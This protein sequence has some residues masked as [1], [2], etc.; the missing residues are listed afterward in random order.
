MFASRFEALIPARTLTAVA[1]CLTLLAVG[2][3]KKP[4]RAAPPV[5][6]PSIEAEPRPAP[7][8]QSAPNE[9]P[10]PAPEPAPA[11]TPPSEEQKPKPK[12]HKSAPKKPAPPTPTESK[13]EPVKPAAPGNSAQI[14]AAI[15]RA[16]MQSQKQE[17]EQL[18]YNSQGRLGGIN[19][20]L[21]DSEQG[22]LQQAR[23]YIVQ[24][25][26]ALQA[27]DIERAYNLAV[28]ANLLTNELTK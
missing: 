20:S 4:V 10:N 13:S 7:L 24:S 8:P 1:L 15:P 21:S 26:Q 16:A 12:P 17:T 28:K 25:N 14:T 5:L 27:G 6:V 22:M 2:C 11:A 18:L 23:N 9:N 19:R 3:E